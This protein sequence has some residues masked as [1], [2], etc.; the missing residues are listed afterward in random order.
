MLRLTPQCQKAAADWCDACFIFFSVVVEVPQPPGAA[1]QRVAGHK[2]LHTERLQ[3]RNRMPLPDQ[4]PLWARQQGE[5]KH[6]H[7]LFPGRAPAFNLSALLLPQWWRASASRSSE[8]CSRRRWR[9]ST[10]TM[11]RRKKSEAIRTWKDVWPVLP[12]TSSSSAWRRATRRWRPSVWTRPPTTIKL[13]N[14][15]IC[16][17]NVSCP[18]F[19]VSKHCAYL[20]IGMK[21]QFVKIDGNKFMWSCCPCLCSFIYSLWKAFQ[22]QT[23]Y[24]LSIF[25]VVTPLLINKFFS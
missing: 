3:W 21:N 20:L 23:E 18:S 13:G 14:E 10:P 15:L 16:W 5:S 7:T 4:V 12:L 1:T 9:R 22:S 8:A 17:D 2:G 24:L 25:V 11:S 19:P 6:T